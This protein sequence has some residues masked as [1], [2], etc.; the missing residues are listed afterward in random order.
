MSYL[1]K[2]IKKSYEERQKEIKKMGGVFNYLEHYVRNHP[3]NKE[4]MYTKRKLQT[5]YAS[6]SPDSEYSFYKKITMYHE[7]HLEH[8]LRVLHEVGFFLVS[9]QGRVHE[10]DSKGTH[11]R[12]QMDMSTGKPATEKDAE[13]FIKLVENVL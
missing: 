4:L 11:E 8:Y 3:A 10:K 1:E 12:F 2:H 5:E 7:A 13:E 9:G 6:D